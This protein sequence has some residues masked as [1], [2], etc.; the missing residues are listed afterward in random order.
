MENEG[1]VDFQQFN[2]YIFTNT[3]GEGG[4]WLENLPI[5]GG[6][7]R[8]LDAEYRHQTFSTPGGF[9]SAALPILLSA[10]FLIVF[11]MV[12]WGAIE[13]MLGANDPKSAD[14]GKKRITAAV[15]GFLILFSSYWI[16]QILQL[17]FGINIGLQ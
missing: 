11:V 9:I 5:F 14:A 12:V 15:I 1:A 2:R 17:I 13:I 16:G 4:S 7:V 10:G 8:I 3:S 6:I